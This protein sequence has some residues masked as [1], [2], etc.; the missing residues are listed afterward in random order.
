MLQPLVYPICWL[1]L[2]HA[3]HL[4]FERRKEV[5]WKTIRGLGLGMLNLL[6]LMDL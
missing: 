4:L 2:D 3:N 1:S 6:S 5:S